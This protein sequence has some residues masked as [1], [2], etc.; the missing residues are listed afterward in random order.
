MAV[1][2]LDF[3]PNDDVT[4]DGKGGEDGREGCLAID[5]PKWNVVHLYAIGKVADAG[6]AWVGVGDD[7]DFMATVYEFLDMSG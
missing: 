2:N 6:A 5:G 1:D 3:L 4:E 7:D